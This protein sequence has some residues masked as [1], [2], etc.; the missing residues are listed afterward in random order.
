[1]TVYCDI[2]QL[3]VD[4][5]MADFTLQYII[6]IRFTSTNVNTSEGVTG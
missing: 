5:I 6:N 3:M 1:M 4:H 2:Y